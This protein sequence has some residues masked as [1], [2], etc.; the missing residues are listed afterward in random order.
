MENEICS[1]CGEDINVGYPH[2]LRC[3]HKFHYQCLYLSFKNLK[4]N[5]CPYCRSPNNKLPLV[6]GL[7]Y[8]NVN[9]HDVTNIEAY[10][11]HKCGMEIMRGKNKGKKCGKSCT[12]GYDY[13]KI[14]LKKYIKE[15]GEINTDNK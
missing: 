10:T 15:H 6:N 11:N 9:I 1:I 4:N 8:I 3:N 14:H 13:C 2:T 7:R 12:L 5:D